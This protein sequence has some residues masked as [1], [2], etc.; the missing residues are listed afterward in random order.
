MM[1]VL[2]MVSIIDEEFG[3]VTY[4]KAVPAVIFGSW[5]PF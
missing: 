5:K 2:G 3:F 1:Q 4:H